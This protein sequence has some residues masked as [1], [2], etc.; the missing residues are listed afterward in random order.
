VV[1]GEHKNILR[2]GCNGRSNTQFMVGNGLRRSILG[3][4]WVSFWGQWLPRPYSV[5]AEP[6]TGDKVRC[7][8]HYILIGCSDGTAIIPT[9]PHGIICLLEPSLPLS[10]RKYFDDW[11]PDFYVLTARARK[12]VSKLRNLYKL[13]NVLRWDKIERTSNSIRHATFFWEHSGLS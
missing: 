2:S 8:P 4:P 12:V 5:E 13:W 3:N 10:F 11:N 1:G 6:G 7:R 9:S